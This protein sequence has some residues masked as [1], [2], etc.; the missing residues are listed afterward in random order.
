MSTLTP[1]YVDLDFTTV[2]TKIEEQLGESNLLNNLNYAGSNISILIE[3]FAYLS[4]LSTFY[5]NKIAKNVYLD[6]A[7]VY[8][9]VSRLAQLVGYYPRGYLAADGSIKLTILGNVSEGSTVTIP[10]WSEVWTTPPTEEDAYISGTDAIYYVIPNEVSLAYPDDFTLNETTGYYEYSDINVKQ[11]VVRSYSYT[12]ADLV[13]NI[14]YLPLLNFDHDQDLEDAVPSVQIIINDEE[15]TR[16]NDFYEDLSG[17]YNSDQVYVLRYNKYKNYVIE[18]SD[19][20]SVPSTTDIIEVKL[21]ETLGD[22]GAVGSDWITQATSDLITILTSAGSEYNL[23]VDDFVINNDANTTGADDP[24]NIATI[25]E[26]ARGMAFTQYRCVTKQ[27]YINYL[28]LHPNIS[29]A[30]VWGEQE[31]N[32]TTNGNVQN[33]NKVYISIVPESPWD[34]KLIYT[35]DENDI[36]IASEYDSSFL[37]TISEYLEPRKMISTYES[38]IVPDFVYFMFSVS[39][40]I[41]SNYRYI[42]VLKDLRNKLSYYFVPENRSFG[43]KFSFN[44]MIDF[45][46]DQTQ[47]SSTN[48]F[49]KTAGIINLNI[50]DISIYDIYTKS[51][52]NPYS[53]GSESYPK[54]LYYDTSTWDENQ[55]KVLQLNYNQFPFLSLTNCTFSEETY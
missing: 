27:D 34:N 18:F 7:D 32:P 23:D 50:R 21:I 35:I 5:L 13:D 26:N 17:L 14:I 31:Q 45:I 20:R 37:T 4:E 10:A 44:D 55:L 54:V 52:R 41:K 22:E 43:E 8:E 1:N 3:L 38:F 49:S 2:K 15:W 33:Y 39:V 30:N 48:N 28:L 9:N 16:I 46:F 53:Y 47:V 6:S 24:E 19:T 36:Q 12:G 25:K 51:W 11:G 42:E 40:R 29:D